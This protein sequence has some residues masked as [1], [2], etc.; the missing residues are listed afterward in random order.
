MSKLGLSKHDALWNFEYS[1]V[2]LL[3]FAYYEQ[4]SMDDSQFVWSPIN[5]TRRLQQ[6]LNGE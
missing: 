1:E 2:M 6:I 4:N 3:M 5:Y